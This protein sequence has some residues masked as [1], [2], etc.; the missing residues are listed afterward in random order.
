MA[1]NT[2]HTTR[3]E[4][5][6]F[7]LRRNLLNGA[8]AL[9]ERLRLPELCNE[10][11][12]S[13]T[14]LRE[15][16]VR[17]TEQGLIKFEANRGYWVPSYTAEDIEDL[18]FVRT[19]VECLALRASIERGDVGWSA[20][21]VAAQHRLEL[22]PRA[23]L[24]DDPEGNEQWSCEHRLFH[25][26]L[27]SACGSPRLLTYRRQLFDEAEMMRQLAGTLSRIERPV[28]DEH[29]AIA[30]AAVQ[31]DADR[32]CELMSHH[33]KITATNALSALPAED[34]PAAAEGERPNT[35]RARQTS[36]AGG[37]ST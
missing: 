26:A 11:G 35:K 19:H 10:Y 5:V 17:L 24:I 28:E 29:A 13:A 21:V 2:N 8:F 23:S 22:T 33:L 31:R 9:G 20:R 1:K 32:A 4:F 12:V 6:Y 37:R 16:L 34:D 7:A 27:V 3:N 25:E 18:V 15:G 30:E 36:S 14:V